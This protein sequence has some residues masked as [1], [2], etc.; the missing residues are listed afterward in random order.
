MINDFSDALD[1]YFETI[2]E[3]D[4]NI[5]EALDAA[6]EEVREALAVLEYEYARLQD[7]HQKMINLR[8]Y[9]VSTS[10]FAAL[11]VEFKAFETFVRGLTAQVSAASAYFEDASEA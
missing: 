7:F 10:P 8:D 2:E 4:H 9:V 3:A 6:E 11:T 1:N 5:M